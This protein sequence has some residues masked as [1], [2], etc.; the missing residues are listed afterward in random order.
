MPQPWTALCFERG[1]FEVPELAKVWE[2]HSIHP[3]R[4]HMY[5]TINSN[6]SE[7]SLTITTPDC[8]LQSLKQS[9]QYC[10]R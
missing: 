3:L 2:G 1:Y 7:E 4:R 9:F 5:V 10:K 8:T 6:Y